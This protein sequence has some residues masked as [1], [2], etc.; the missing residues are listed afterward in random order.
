M[1]MKNWIVIF[2]I[3]IPLLS[4]CVTKESK[5]RWQIK[6]ENPA[7]GLTL[8]YLLPFDQIQKIVG[9]KF[10]PAINDEGMG[11]LNLTIMTSNQYY[12]GGKSYGD[13]QEAHILIRTKGSVTV[14]LSMGVKGQQ[15][16]DAF[17][18]NNF[19]ES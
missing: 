6:K 18:E 15:L 1:N 19:I 13:M 11:Y 12:L 16:N 17:S 7:Y 2:S 3:S 5:V 10:Q 8:S 4:A 14:P 9:N